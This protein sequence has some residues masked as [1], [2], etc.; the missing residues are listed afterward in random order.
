MSQKCNF[1]SGVEGPP[2]PLCGA[3][4]AAHLEEHDTIRPSTP[5]PRPGTWA[6]VLGSAQSRV[7]MTRGSDGDREMFLCTGGQIT[8]RAKRPLSNNAR[9]Q[10]RKEHKP[11]FSDSPPTHQSQAGWGEIGARFKL[12]SFYCLNIKAGFFPLAVLQINRLL[13]IYFLFMAII[14]RGL[15]L[16]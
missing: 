2:A 14:A 9:S 5:Q 15:F 7:T 16:V 12:I 1:T 3:L 10:E 13:Y 6:E 4:E 11:P 8:T